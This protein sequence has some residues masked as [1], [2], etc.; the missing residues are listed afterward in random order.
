ML[1]LKSKMATERRASWPL[2]D[3]RIVES[4]K[5]QLILLSYHRGREEQ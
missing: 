1:N 5:G 2:F 4:I 3:I